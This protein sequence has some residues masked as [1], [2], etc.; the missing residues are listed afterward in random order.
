MLKIRPIATVPATAGNDAGAVERDA[1]H[2]RA[3]RRD[4]EAERGGADAAV[5][6]GGRAQHP[7]GLHGRRPRRPHL[8]LLLRP[9]VLHHRLHHYR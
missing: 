7:A 4:V 1:A 6:G 8:D 9:H 3:L 2:E 5:P